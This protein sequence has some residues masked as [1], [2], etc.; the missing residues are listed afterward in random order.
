MTPVPYIIAYD[1]R[2]K[3]RLTK[4]HKVICSYAISLQYSVFYAELNQL[5]IRVLVSK[6]NKIINKKEDDVRIYPV[7]PLSGFQVIGAKFID[8]GIYAFDLK[9]KPI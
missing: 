4:I 8:Y 9:N 2:E 7:E 1:I 5:Q 6:L 3:R